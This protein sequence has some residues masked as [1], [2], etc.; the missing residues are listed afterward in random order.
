MLLTFRVLKVGKIV[1]SSKYQ[2][3]KIEKVVRWVNVLILD[4]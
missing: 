3:S 4:T 1:A 2:V